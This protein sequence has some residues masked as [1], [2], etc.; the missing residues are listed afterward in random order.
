MATNATV[1]EDCSKGQIYLVPGALVLRTNGPCFTPATD[2]IVVDICPTGDDVVAVLNPT[3]SLHLQSP[4]GCVFEE[5]NVNRPN[6]FQ[7]SFPTPG[8]KTHIQAVFDFPEPTPLKRL[9]S[10]SFRF[11]ITGRGANDCTV[12]IDM[13]ADIVESVTPRQYRCQPALAIADG[14]QPPTPAFG[15]RR[16]GDPDYAQLRIGCPPS[17]ATGGADGSE[18]GAFSFLH[19][20]QLEANLRMRLDEYLPIGLEAGLIYMDY[21]RR[22]EE[23]P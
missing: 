20:P 16:F 5:P 17:I 19:Q 14:N 15:S 3:V 23:Q 6:H 12:E 2:E 21:I 22:F 13:F 1:T 11:P 8:D 18:M 7:Y 10:L 9:N 4:V